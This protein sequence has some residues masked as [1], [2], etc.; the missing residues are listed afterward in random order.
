MH[1][2]PFLCIIFQSTNKTNRNNAHIRAY[3]GKEIQIIYFKA[4]CK[5]FKRVLG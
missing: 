5:R 1:I 2:F 4:I 3:I